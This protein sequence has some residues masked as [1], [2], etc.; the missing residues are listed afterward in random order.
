MDRCMS[1]CFPQFI[2]TFT[3]VN[4][5]KLVCVLM[6]PKSNTPVKDF[7]NIVH[8]DHQDGINC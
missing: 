5:L 4:L 8:D 2:V 6:K 7:I 3:L 1:F